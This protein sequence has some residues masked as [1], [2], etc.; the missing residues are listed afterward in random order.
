MLQVPTSLAYFVQ[1]RMV[2][3]D[4]Y[5]ALE[6]AKGNGVPIAAG[7][8]TGVYVACISFEYATVLE[9]G[10]FKVLGRSPLM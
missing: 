8:E 6:G 3:E 10:G 7:S 9:R 5:A 2:L 1:L 4:S